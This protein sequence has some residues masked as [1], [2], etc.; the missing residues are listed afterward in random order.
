MCIRL[1]GPRAEQDV[2][3]IDSG[4]K[5]T[6]VLR[7]RHPSA[8]QTSRVGLI[9]EQVNASKRLRNLLLR[10]VQSTM[11]RVGFSE[12]DWGLAAPS[13]SIQPQAERIGSA[14]PGGPTRELQ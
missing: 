9:G 5:T 8:V 10:I 6:A 13:Q 7:H 1:A 4:A 14:I 3:G 11:G 2:L 12:I